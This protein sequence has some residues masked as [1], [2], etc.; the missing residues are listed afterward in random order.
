MI[1]VK[2]FSSLSQ[3][4]DLMCSVIK[5]YLGRDKQKEKFFFFLKQ[6]YTQFKLSTAFKKWLNQWEQ[7]K[8]ILIMQNLQVMKMISLASNTYLHDKNKK[9]KLCQLFL[10]VQTFY[11]TE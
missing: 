4:L 1:L 9:Q 7:W 6:S 5:F 2:F 11:V 3:N 8:L 10:K